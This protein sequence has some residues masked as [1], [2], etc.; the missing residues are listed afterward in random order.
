MKQS[1]FLLFGCMLISSIT[2][3][4]NNTVANKKASTENIYTSQFTDIESLIMRKYIDTFPEPSNG[5][6]VNFI[7]STQGR[8]KF[9]ID[10]SL[11]FY[12]AGFPKY[13][14]ES[15]IIDISQKS[16]K[17]QAEIMKDVKKYQ[18]SSQDIQNGDI[19]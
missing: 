8:E 1:V 15:Q 13:K 9:T 18:N 11:R 4:Q 7:K 2:F 19:T 10:L 14:L 3:S 12:V 17:L 6:F 5:D 16:T